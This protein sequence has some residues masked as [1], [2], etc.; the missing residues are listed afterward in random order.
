MI[1]LGMQSSGDIG[2]NDWM[3]QKRQALLSSVA[4]GMKKALP[5][6]RAALGQ[7]LSSKLKVRKANFAATAM[8]GAVME[9]PGVAPITVF[10]SKVAWL[11]AHAEGVTIR[12]RRGKGVLIPINKGG[13]G[14]IGY[15]AFKRM[16]AQLDAASRLDFRLINGKVIVF[17]KASGGKGSSQRGKEVAIAVLVPEVTLPKRLDFKDL[18]AAMARMAV[19]GIDKELSKR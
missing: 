11:S 2:G 8:P 5:Q 1:K 7:L 18:S 6:Q 9:K 14:R 10:R 16:I 15:Q 13:D 17:A 19:E 3:K 4:Q 12:G